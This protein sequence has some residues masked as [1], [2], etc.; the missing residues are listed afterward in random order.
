MNEQLKLDV[1]EEMKKAGFDQVE[2]INSLDFSFYKNVL[3]GILSVKQLGKQF[4]ESHTIMGP[5]LKAIVYKIADQY[6]EKK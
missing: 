2:N 4:F 3:K 1:I 6:T 5:K